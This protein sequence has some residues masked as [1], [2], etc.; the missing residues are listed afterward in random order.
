ME[1]TG[2]VPQPERFDSHLIMQEIGKF[3]LEVNVIPN[4]MEK[5][6]SFSLGKNVVFIDAVQFMASSLSPLL[7]T[8][9][10]KSYVK[11]VRDE[12]ERTS[13]W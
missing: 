6:I 10:R 2:G 11:S 3:D 4:N 12:K 8:Y 7:V 1:D 5:Y 9:R 13:I